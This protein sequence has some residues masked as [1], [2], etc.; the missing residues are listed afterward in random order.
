MSKENLKVSYSAEGQSKILYSP[1]VIEE[2]TSTIKK[3][4]KEDI[5]RDA[6]Y[7]EKRKELEIEYIRD[8]NCGY[9]EDYTTWIT[10][11]FISLLSNFTLVNNHRYELIKELHNIKKDIEPTE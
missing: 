1:Q 4:K 2:L 3:W 11:R 6:L 8:T 7:K 5:V 9:K 10:S